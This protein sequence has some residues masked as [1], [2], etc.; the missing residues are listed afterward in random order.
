MVRAEARPA[1]RCG[2]QWAK[3][4]RNRHVREI[5]TPAPR[6]GDAAAGLLAPA[7]VGCPRAWPAGSRRRQKLSPAS[8][9]AARPGLW[10][11]GLK[12]AAAKA[13]SVRAR[14]SR[15][16][17]AGSVVRR[18][19]LC[20]GGV[21]HRCGGG[22]RECLAGV[23]A[24]RCGRGGERQG[25][26]G[27]RARRRALSSGALLA[28]LLLCSACRPPCCRPPPQT[29]HIPARLRPDTASCPTFR[30]ACSHACPAV[31][32]VGASCRTAFRGRLPPP[33][34]PRPRRAGSG[35]PPPRR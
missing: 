11:T 10:M 3:G 12:P 28:R 25:V 22:Y 18:G 1:R 20:A 34:P 35:G 14:P 31:P 13:P 16:T 7:A 32:H 23:A 24:D 30:R 29:V 8:P 26:A 15:C 33:L 2:R 5:N 19:W 6:S 21:S 4:R 9:A 27:R 17:T